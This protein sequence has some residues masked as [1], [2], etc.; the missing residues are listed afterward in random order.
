LKPNLKR[1]KDETQQNEDLIISL[2]SKMKKPEMI[3]KHK[4]TM[5]L[6]KKPSLQKRT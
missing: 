2:S 1:S 3:L 5:K 4:L 6:S